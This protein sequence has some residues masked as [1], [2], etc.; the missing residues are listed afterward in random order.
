MSTKIRYGVIG[1]GNIAK[2][3]HLPGYSAFPE[4]VEIV[5][6]CDIDEGRLEA[7]ANEFRIPKRFT[8]YWELLKEDLDLVSIC[9]PNHL[10]A[11]VSIAALQSGKHVHCEK[12]MAMNHAEAAT[13]REAALKY[14]RRLMVGVN[15]RFTPESQY[16]KQYIDSGALG[17]IYFARCGWL[18]RAGSAPWGWFTDRRQ[19]GGGPLI[20]LGVHFID[21][22][23]YFLGYPEL[24]SISAKAHKGTIDRENAH[25][26]EYFGS[27]PTPG[28]VFD[29]EDM[30]FGQ[31]DLANDVSLQFEVSWAS[32]IE[33]EHQFYTI[34]GTKGSVEFYNDWKPGSGVTIH[35]IFG[36][37]HSDIRPQISANLFGVNEF[38][39]LIDC[40]R[41]NRAPT[42]SVLEQAVYVL[43]IIDGIYESSESG[44]PVAFPPRK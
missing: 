6:A 31:L 39:H 17:D 9:L 38:K 33:N 16:V 7:V 3:K 28:T 12:P 11:Q 44:R 22:A 21:L 32:H 26:Y 24:R 20:D 25:L 35:T 14:D 29:V 40:I 37:A 1:T 27:R 23:M 8:D 41:A 34:Y 30:A 19:S 13:M 43:D 2:G 36:G 15:N 4:D 10:H 18:R 42:V 5:A